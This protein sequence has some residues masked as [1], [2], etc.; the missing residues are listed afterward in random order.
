MMRNKYLE[1]SI[2][3]QNKKLL[4]NRI[5]NNDS[6]SL[7]LANISLYIWIIA[8]GNCI[9]FLILMSEYFVKKHIS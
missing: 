8:S 3:F 7:H 4:S 9:S 2:S 5:G 6:T 1:D